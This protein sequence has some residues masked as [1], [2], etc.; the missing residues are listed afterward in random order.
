[1]FKFIIKRSLRVLIKNRLIIMVFFSL[2]VFIIFSTGVACYELGMSKTE[3]FLF[4]ATIGFFVLGSVIAGGVGH[5]KGEYLP[6]LK[7]E[8]I[9]DYK[10]KSNEPITKE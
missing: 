5:F 10:E 8:Y 6:K 2:S 4:T 7:K 9:N 1:M 3:I